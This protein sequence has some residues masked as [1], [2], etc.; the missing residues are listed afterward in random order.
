M[1]S[2]WSFTSRADV[3]IA[4]GCILVVIA[5]WISVVVVFPDGWV[6]F[7]VAL[8][9]SL[10][11]MLKEVPVGSVI[12]GIGDLVIQVETLSVVSD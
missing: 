9:V 8:V 5:G 1:A 11:V 3:S 7:I 6:V 4:V 10:A 2:I 12:K